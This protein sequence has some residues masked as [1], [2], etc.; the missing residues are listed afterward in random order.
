MVFDRER[1]LVESAAPAWLEIR[2]ANARRCGGTLVGIVERE[3]PIA[4]PGRAVELRPKAARGRA[5]EGVLEELVA[6][7][8]SPEGRIGEHTPAGHTRFTVGGREW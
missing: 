8:V 4:E 5:Q 3:Y 7:P 6:E 2:A 1:Q